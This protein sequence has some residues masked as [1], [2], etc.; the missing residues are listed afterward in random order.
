MTAVSTSS[1]VATIVAPAPAGAIAPVGDQPPAELM[2]T[3][4]PDPPVAAPV[5]ATP[6]A[7]SAATAVESTGELDLSNRVAH[8]LDSVLFCGLPVTS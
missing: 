6:A 4:E 2:D 1:S 3:G 5:T 8:S 7:A